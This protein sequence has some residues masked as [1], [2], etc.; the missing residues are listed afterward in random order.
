MSALKESIGEATK[1]AMRARAK[2]RLAALRLMNAEI[3]RVEVDTRKILSDDDIL[4]I[5]NRMLKQRQDSLQQYEAAGREDL[6]AV[7][8]QEIEVIREFMPAPLSDAELE[9]EINAAVTATG[10]SSPKDM[11]ALMNVLRPR[12]QGRADMGQVSA[13]VKARLAG[14]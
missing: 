4:Q 12:V 7:E 6:A 11:G 3:K 5:L 8:R 9:A 10:A 14:G 13:R 2:E 1:D